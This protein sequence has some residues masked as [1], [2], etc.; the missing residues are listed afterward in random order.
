MDGM[1][2]FPDP[3]IWS[4]DEGKILDKGEI[5][6]GSAGALV[7]NAK[8]LKKVDAVR[9]ASKDSD[10]SSAKRSLELLNDC[11]LLLRPELIFSDNKK[12]KF[13]ESIN[14]NSVLL[15]QKDF[16]AGAPFS[17]A[18]R[19][20]N[21][22]VDSRGFMSANKKSIQK[23]FPNNGCDDMNCEKSLFVRN[24]MQ[25]ISNKENQSVY[26]QSLD[27]REDSS[28]R[29]VFKQDDWNNAIQTHALGFCSALDCRIESCRALVLDVGIVYKTKP[30]TIAVGTA[31]PV[32]TAKKLK[33][34]DVF[35]RFVKVHLKSKCFQADQ[36][37]E[38]EDSLCW[39]TFTIFVGVKDDMSS[40]C[41]FDTFRTIVLEEILKMNESN[42]AHV[43]TISRHAPMYFVKSLI[44]KQINSQAINSTESLISGICSLKRTFVVAEDISPSVTYTD[45]YISF[46]TSLLETKKTKSKAHLIDQE[47]IDKYKS[48][49]QYLDYC[50]GFSQSFNFLLHDKRVSF[51]DLKDIHI[52][53]K[54]LNLV[55]SPLPNFSQSDSFDVTAPPQEKLTTA[56]E[57]KLL[58]FHTRW[59]ILLNSTSQSIFKNGLTD[60]HR[61]SWLA[62]LEH[63]R[64]FNM[65]EVSGGDID[66]QA[67]IST[68]ALVGKKLLMPF[69]DDKYNAS[70]GGF[71]PSIT[72]DYPHDSRS[73]ADFF[74]HAKVLTTAKGHKQGYNAGV[75]GGGLEAIGEAIKSLVEFKKGEGELAIQP[76]KHIMFK[77][78]YEEGT[79]DFDFTAN[80]TSLETHLLGSLLSKEALGE[81]Y[82][83]VWNLG[84]FKVGEKDKTW[85]I[86]ILVKLKNSK[87]L[88]FSWDEAKKKLLSEIAVDQNISR[89]IECIIEIVAKASLSDNFFDPF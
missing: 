35:P 38:T 82:Q 45:L 51:G 84:S 65:Q 61:D 64:P 8:G 80:V 47:Y 40:L 83:R 22:Y 16:K 23:H 73:V 53:V 48:S 26:S 9:V 13:S 18:L 15:T 10:S 12:P 75:G 69:D 1:T 31:K 6:K 44:G 87:Y 70:W 4:L 67:M 14:N 74:K 41:R 17:E 66:R 20:L 78:V 2:G 79:P 28:C 63:T 11:P 21:G 27:N 71:P 56:S 68:D 46:G 60:F 77:R 42:P 33:A 88:V 52:P 5:R 3:I 36:R 89:P 85:E 59:L 72:G 30:E 7:L 54:V 29:L 25:D 57:N 62:F 32:F 76:P 19:L 43:M 86:K 58:S 49:Q 81:S 24:S 34:N 50:G 37:F 39:T 55:G